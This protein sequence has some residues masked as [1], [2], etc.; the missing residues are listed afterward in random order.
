[1]SLVVD[2]SMV[3]AGLVDVGAAGTWAESLLATEAL[4]APHLM[5]VEA[6]NILRRATLVGDIS[7]D[8]AA[9]AHRDLGE[10]RVELLPYAPFADRVWELRGNVTAYDG[11]YVA[12]AESLDAPLATIDLRLGRAPGPRC[13]FATPPAEPAAPLRAGG[14]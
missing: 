14:R 6:T 9:L 3:V 10:L 1:V 2:A 13:A 8:A 4:A 12:V 7:A 11:W 5:P